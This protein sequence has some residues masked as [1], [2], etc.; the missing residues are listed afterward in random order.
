[1]GTYR[2]YYSI[3]S[4][5]KALILAGFLLV[6]VGGGLLMYLKMPKG[7]F[8]IVDAPIFKEENEIEELLSGQVIQKTVGGDHPNEQQESGNSW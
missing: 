3:L 2:Y 8:T 4:P 5:D 6:L 1:M 7:G